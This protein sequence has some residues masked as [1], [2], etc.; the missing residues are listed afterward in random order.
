[1][2]QLPRPLVVVSLALL[3]GACSRTKAPE[4]PVN[5]VVSAPLE[6]DGSRGGPPLVVG[7]T[8]PRERAKKSKSKSSPAPEDSVLEAEPSALEAEPTPPPA[9]PQDVL[10][11]SSEGMVLA[12]LTAVESTPQDEDEGVDMDA[13]SATIRQRMPALE[14][15]YEQTSNAGKHTYTIT[16]EPEGQVSTVVIEEDTLQEQ[17]IADCAVE[18]IRRWSFEIEAE[19]DAFPVTFSVQFSP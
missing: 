5:I 17:D 14:A 2:R 12:D 18:K 13:I 10:G 16:I 11:E 1:M 19:T 3:V 8:P 7:E 6:D 15:C 9:P 4:P